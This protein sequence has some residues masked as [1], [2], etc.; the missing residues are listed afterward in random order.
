M[1]SSTSFYSNTLGSGVEG[2][3]PKLTQRK[4]PAWSAVV[5]THPLSCKLVDG[6]DWNWTAIKTHLRCRRLPHESVPYGQKNR[7]RFFSRIYLNTLALPSTYLSSDR[8]PIL[9][10]KRIAIISEKA[11]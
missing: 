4:T 8:S 7:T 5:W 3:V 2:R 9:H 11:K 10:P 6:G 1:G